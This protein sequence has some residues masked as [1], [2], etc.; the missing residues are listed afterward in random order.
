VPADHTFEIRN[1]PHDRKSLLQVLAPTSHEGA[2][3]TAKKKRVDALF[4]KGG[5]IEMP[6][7]LNTS[8]GLW[9]IGGKTRLGAANYIKGIPAKVWMIDG[10]QDVTKGLKESSG[11][12]PTAAEANDPRFEMALTVDVRPGA[13]GKA[14]N[15][16]LLN[17]DSQ[18][19]PQE[20]RPDG[21]VNR[22]TEELAL[23]K[24]KQTIKLTENK[25]KFS[26][27]KLDDLLN[28]L[29]EKVIKA[30]EEAPD[31]Y[32]MVAAAVIDPTGRLATGINYLYGNVRIHAERDAIDRYE[33]G[34]GK[35][36][37][38]SIVVTTLSPCNTGHYPNHP[39]RYGEDC[40]E[41]L[42]SRS[43]KFVYCGYKNPEEN[44]D[45]SIETD[46]PKIKKLCKQFADTFLD[47]NTKGIGINVYEN[48]ADGKGPGRT[49]DSVRHGIPKK[50]TQAELTKASHAKGRKGQLAR[51][52]LNM[53]NG[54]NK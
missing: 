53:R 27:D 21:L 44:P 50:A 35:L 9:L 47:E 32:G 41:L 4:A 52:Q 54:R 49:G 40:Q 19:H 13:L 22:M 28:D 24:K 45:S 48:F 23:F 10:N 31:F 14:A 30:Q 34:Y 26:R 25:L 46:N 38:G 29:C 15:A 20:L 43:V 33:E 16:F 6:I 11:Y 37:K 3:G 8:N 51:W 1:A 2:V 39:D 5:S 17:T 12:I 42:D 18:G 36:P 7:V